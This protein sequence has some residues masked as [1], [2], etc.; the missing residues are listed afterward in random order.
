MDA[1]SF[2]EKL[3]ADRARRLNAN[4]AEV[5]GGQREFLLAENLPEN[6]QF[7]WPKEDTEV[8][9]RILPFIVTKEDNIAGQAVGQ[10]ANVR[11]IKVHSTPNKQFK[12][13]PSTYGRPCPICKKYNSFSKEEKQGKNSPATPYKAKE[14]AIFNA[15]FK[16]PGKDGKTRLEV[17]VVKGGAFAGWEQILK[18][19]KGESSI[20]LN[21]KYADKINLF[22]DLEDGYWMDI[23]CNKE[24]ITGGN[25]ASVAFMQ[26]SRINLK[27]KEKAGN[28]PFEAIIPR[29]A[30]LDLVIPPPASADEL[31][32]AFDME[33]AD[34]NEIAQHDTIDEE[35]E[36]MQEEDAIPMGTTEEPSDVI[37]GEELVEEEVPELED[38]TISEDDS[39]AEAEAEEATE[40]PPKESP[41][42]S[43][44]K[45]E[46]KEEVFDDP[47]DDDG[48]DAL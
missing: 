26:F 21:A 18:E 9:I 17:R 14:Y 1:K 19:I 40:E 39:D 8:T 28:I 46:V 15:L 2:M 44:N 36:H 38:V 47:F 11:R 16:V 37:E 31:M 24:S 4:K 25:G 3:R 42:K 5:Q 32:R 29:I 6:N 23:R 10:S 41:K 45:P 22:D 33:E 48:F 30:D 20:K 12:I 7:W 43:K 27:W 13:C 35:F 34:G